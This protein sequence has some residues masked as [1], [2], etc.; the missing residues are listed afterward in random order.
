MV[1]S[2]LKPTRCLFKLAHTG[3]RRGSL[4]HMVVKEVS[5]LLNLETQSTYPIG[6]MY[7]NEIVRLK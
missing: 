3:H 7:A 2:G 1:L 4:L 5:A 6:V